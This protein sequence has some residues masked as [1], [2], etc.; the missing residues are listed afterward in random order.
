L[1]PALTCAEDAECRI[2]PW[3]DDVLLVRRAWRGAVM[4]A[5]I[6]L[7]GA[8]GVDLAGHPMA[9]TTGDLPWATVFSTSAGSAH[10]LT[11]SGDRPAVDFKEPGAVIF[12]AG[13]ARA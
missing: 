10:G 13:G 7:E 1:E 2:E 9:E 3:S 12:M 11:A 6:R 5:V 4:L 8:G